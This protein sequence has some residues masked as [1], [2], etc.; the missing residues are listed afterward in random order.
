MCQQR[1]SDGGQPKDVSISTLTLLTAPV[2]LA[3][4]TAEQSR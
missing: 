2:A 3:L 4:E 1:F